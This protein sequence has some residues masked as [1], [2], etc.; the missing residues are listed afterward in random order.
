MLLCSYLLLFQLNGLQ[1][2]APE[3]D[4]DLDP[5]ELAPE[6]QQLTTCLLTLRL[7]GRFLGFLTF[8]P[9]QTPEKL[10]DSMQAACVAMRNKVNIFKML[11]FYELS[12]HYA[13]IF[14]DPC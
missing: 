9:Y 8:L 6:R 13:R 7:L 10:P 3:S 2:L 1:I 5:I 11:W 14:F 4:I 12:T